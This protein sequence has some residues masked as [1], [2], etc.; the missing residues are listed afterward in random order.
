MNPDFPE[1]LRDLVELAKNTRRQDIHGV[2]PEEWTKWKLIEPL[3]RAL[4][5]DS[6]DIRKEFHILGAQCDYLLE[7]RKPLLFVEAKSLTEKKPL[8][9]KHRDQVL[10]YLRNYRVSPEQVAMAEPVTWLLLTNFAQLHLIRVNEERPSFSFRLDQLEERAAELWELLSAERLEVGRIEELYDQEQKADLDQ[11]F[12]ADLKQWRLILANGFGLRN[13]SASLADLTS[14]S[15]QLLDRFLFCRMLETHGL[16]EY[17]K[18]ARAF[19][20]YDTFFT[21]SAKTFAQF[22]RESLFEEIRAKFNTEL[23][24]QPQ[25]CDTLEI[26]NA[27]LAA[28]I[29]HTSLPAEVALTCG[30]EQGLGPLLS[31]R[32]LY[33]YDFTRMSHDIMG[34]VYER[35]LAHKLQQ[36]NGRVVIEETDEL[37]KKEGIY[38]TPQYIVDYIVSHT[39]GEKTEPIVTAAIALVTEKRFR[40]ALT[41]IRELA[42]LKVLDPSMGSGSFLLRAFDHLLDC[43][44]RYNRACRE[45]KQT[46]RVR[47]TPGELFGAGEE[48][49]EE[50]FNPAFH[51]VAE[52]IFGVDLDPQAVE[53]ARLN[54]WMRL[55]IAERDIMRERLRLTQSNGH[56]LSLLPSLARNLKRGN[57]LIPDLAVAGDAAFDWPAQF[58]EVMERGGFDIVVGNPPY[59]RIQTMAEYAPESL[60]YLK[61]HYKTAEAGNFDIYVCFVERGLNLLNDH[62]LFGYILPHKFFQAGYGRALRSLLTTGKH[63]REIVNFGHAQV[64]PQVST[65][66]CLLFLSKGASASFTLREVSDLSSWSARNEAISATLAAEALNESEWIPAAGEGERALLVR[67]RTIPQTLEDVTTRIFQGLKTSADDIFI[68]DE[69]QR[70]ARGVRVHS[71]ETETEH[72]LEPALLHPLVKGGD[73]RRYVLAEPSRRILFPYAQNKGGAVELIPESVL[74]KDFP[75]TWEY[76][77]A[78]R[79]RLEGREKGKFEGSNWYAFGRDQALDVISQAKIFTPDLALRASYSLDEAGDKFFTGGVAGG[80]GILVREEVNRDYVLA[81]LNSRLLDWYVAKNGT[82]MRGGWHSY[83]ARFIR[84]VPILLPRGNRQKARCKTIADLANRLR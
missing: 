5:F 14:A 34:A 2:D 72:L 41:K 23:F 61:T 50:I 16:I 60:E 21:N 65:Y 74:E 79:K 36:K 69:L 27:F 43:Y 8:F 78:N 13:P 35:F 67:L 44:G 55:M 15:Q 82:T 39:L 62:G 70:G 37:R 28:V 59:E 19:V 46:G 84:S 38:Y 83:E 47:E 17:N 76:L 42:A 64:F 29:G 77:L 66:T 75:L 56:P 68:V 20:G 18:L 22:L 3:F 73:S 33:S 48:V 45:M 57:S 53:L 54:I 51:I 32:H 52:N 30:I 63:L 31:F 40:E 81:L 10:G 58:P 11:R 1:R 80:Y 6:D 9:E 7:R 25:L 26:G 71:H 12:L 49:A 4:G 24:V